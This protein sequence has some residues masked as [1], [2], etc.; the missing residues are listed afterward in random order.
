VAMLEVPGGPTLQVACSWRL[1]AGRDCVIEA[2]FYGTSGGAALRNVAGSFYDFA[3]DRF[4]GTSRESLALP[5]D[6][7]GGR[8]AVA[9]AEALA[10]GARYDQGVEGVVEVAETLDGIY[11]A[12]RPDG[13]GSP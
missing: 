10:R 7:W 8:A 11:A 13:S 1:P 3:V 2:S 4:H 6:A 9:W 5:P 12:A